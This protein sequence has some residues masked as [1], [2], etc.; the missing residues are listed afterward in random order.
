[1][2]GRST[3]PGQPS[4]DAVHSAHPPQTFEDQATTHRRRAGQTPTRPH[5][6]TPMTPSNENDNGGDPEVP[7]EVVDVLRNER[8][9]DLVTELLDEGDLTLVTLAS[10]VA[11]ETD[12]P[13]PDV[14][15]E[16]H[17]VHLPKLTDCGLVDYDSGN[18]DISFALSPETTEAA[19]DRA[20]DDDA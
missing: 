6:F 17:D 3:R 13:L 11:S 4:P 7:P 16:L 19:L 14:V 20:R 10:R 9:R 5:Q 2:P 12:T 8:R 18:G 1:M 15:I